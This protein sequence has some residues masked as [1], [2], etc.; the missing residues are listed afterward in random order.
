MGV[1]PC[2][3]SPALRGGRGKIERK[4]VL[5]QNEVFFFQQVTNAIASACS[6]ILA[7]WIWSRW[8]CVPIQSA[9]GLGLE[10]SK[11]RAERKKR[12]PVPQLPAEPQL[13]WKRNPL[14]LLRA[15][16]QLLGTSG[17]NWYWAAS[18]LTWHSHTSKSCLL[19]C[20]PRQTTRIHGKTLVAHKS[21][22]SD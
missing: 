18:V 20:W 19:G 1:V 2:E 13:Q 15:Y 4:Q 10:I 12:E 8:V 11:H 17:Q 16:T 3:K 6:F 21:C 5:L 22:T 9:K 14:L 7:S